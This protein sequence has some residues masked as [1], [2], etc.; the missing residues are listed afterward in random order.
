MDWGKRVEGIT[1]FDLQ[2]MAL[3]IVCTACDMTKQTEENNFFDIKIT[4]YIVINDN[5][6]DMVPNIV[7]ILLPCPPHTHTYTRTHNFSIYSLIH[8]LFIRPHRVCVYL[9]ELYFDVI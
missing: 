6:T 9:I 4:I 2:M 7:F 5:M 3:F 8:S 1:V